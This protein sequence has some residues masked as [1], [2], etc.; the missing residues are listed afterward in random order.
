[1]KID[2]PLVAILV[3]YP[4]ALFGLFYLVSCGLYKQTIK[5]EKAVEQAAYS[6]T[7]VTQAITKRVQ[8]SEERAA[9]NHVQWLA[10]L[11]YAVIGAGLAVAYFAE[12]LKRR[13]RLFRESRHLETGKP[14]KGV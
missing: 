4:F 14:R 13:W 7:N 3:A 5:T 12:E 6:T 11:K 2:R 9:E 1:M 10:L 8:G